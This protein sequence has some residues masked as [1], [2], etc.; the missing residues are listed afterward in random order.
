MS[1]LPKVAILSLL[2]FLDLPQGT[3][4]GIVLLSLLLGALR[5]VSQVDLKKVLAYRGIMNT[6]FMLDLLLL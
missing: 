2:I 4:L 1:L 6:G 3:L 5:G